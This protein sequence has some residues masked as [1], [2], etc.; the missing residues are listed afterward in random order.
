MTYQ[1]GKED[2]RLRPFALAGLGAAFL[3]TSGIP[4]ETK[5][6]WAVG[7]G[8]KL[9][10][11]ERTGIKLQARYAPTRLNDADAAP[12]CDPLGFCSGTLKQS[13]FFAGL[14]LRF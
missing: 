8:V 14:V 7:G 10:L 13:E 9:R 11:G 2:A 4:G 1:W 6:S 3:S 12:F 5:F